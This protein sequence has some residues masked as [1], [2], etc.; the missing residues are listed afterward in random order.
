MMKEPSLKSRIV[1]VALAVG[2]V[3]VV[4]LV[5]RIRPSDATRIPTDVSVLCLTKALTQPVEFRHVVGCET[6]DCCPG[7]PAPDALSWDVRL[8]GDF[9]RSLSLRFDNLA[10][11][12]ASRVVLTGKAAWSDA[13]T[14]EIGIGDS[15]ISGLPGNPQM[16]VILGTGQFVLDPA[17]VE[18]LRS[19]AR[20]VS[21][22]GVD[23]GQMSVRVIQMLDRVAVREF[24]W[25]YVARDCAG[26]DPPGQDE[27]HLLTKSG[28]DQATLLVDGRQPTST[29]T[30]DEQFRTPTNVGIGN[31]LSSGSCNAEVAV[32]AV[33]NAMELTPASWTDAA[34]DVVDVKMKPVIKVPLTVWIVTGPASQRIAEMN[35]FV[36]SANALY[37]G[38]Q[39]GIKFEPIT[40]ISKVSS[41]VK[42]AACVRDSA[43]AASVADGPALKSKVG[44]V[45]GQ[46]NVYYVSH[47]RGDRGEACELDP[48][49]PLLHP[50]L[51]PVTN[52]ILVN[53]GW[54]QFDPAVLAHEIGHTFSLCHIVDPPPPAAP[55]IS[56]KNLM[57]TSFTKRD[58]ITTGQLFRVNV[59]KNSSLNFNKN[60]SGST[61]D[62][63]GSSSS[64]A[65]P[66]LALDVWPK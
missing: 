6:I 35:Q 19:R 43:M 14:I 58:R 10:P 17:A 53:A 64:A 21:R 2:S 47:A 45:S 65:C 32:F 60:R 29:C 50:N 1:S 46:L 57:R 48:S 5:L 55:E 51:H 61:R 30:D 15:R 36:N 12:A 33:D 34:G 23:L 22:S 9:V 66:P 56:S 54:A 39:G 59:N 63:S 38:M 41:T 24:E 44:F 25:R 16:P 18:R 8:A 13:N 31:F 27:I 20:E 49:C 26:L 42:Q 7:C 11:E 52:M 37:N 40:M 28:G 3:L 62:C 4:A